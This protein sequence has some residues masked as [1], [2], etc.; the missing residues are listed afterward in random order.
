V[1]TG[2][3]EAEDEGPFSPLVRRQIEQAIEEADAL[4]L[5][6]D[7]RDGL[8]AADLGSPRMFAG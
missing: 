4:A 2:R 1:D 7:A 8:T 3:L 5:V 6:V